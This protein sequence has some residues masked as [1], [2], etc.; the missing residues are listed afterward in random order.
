MNDVHA[1]VLG[2]RVVR[3]RSYDLAVADIGVQGLAACDQRQMSSEEKYFGAFSADGLIN[4]RYDNIT[5]PTCQHCRVLLDQALESPLPQ[6]PPSPPDAD[7]HRNRTAR[8]G[9]SMSTAAERRLAYGIAAERLRHDC[10]ADFGGHDLRLTIGVVEALDEL[11]ALMDAA[12]KDSAPGEP[13]TRYELRQWLD[14]N[15]PTKGSK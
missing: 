6:T 4:Q 1:S 9:E 8:A 14:R 10:P 12:S 13:L 11:I 3:R 7:G 2:I 5:W 15:P